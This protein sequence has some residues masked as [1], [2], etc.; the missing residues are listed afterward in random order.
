M[1]ASPV[2]VESGVNVISP[3]V[4]WRLNVPLPAISTELA[5]QF[6]GV[7]PEAQSFKV[8]AESVVLLFWQIGAGAIKLVTGTGSIVAVIGVLV[9]LVHPTGNASI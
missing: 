6:G 3:L 7:S 5:V 4:G 1:E 8:E 2:K 9:L